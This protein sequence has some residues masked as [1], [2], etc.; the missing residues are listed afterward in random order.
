M[1]VYECLRCKGRV[2]AKDK[3]EAI[4]TMDHAVGQSRG[5]PCAG[6]DGAPLYEVRD[7][8][9]PTAPTPT[10]TVKVETESKPEKPTE[11]EKSKAKKS[12]KS[13]E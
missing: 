7:A 1:A 5:R 11:P 9:E 4:I 13:D 12:S 6:G 8:P 3:A 10:T 2:E